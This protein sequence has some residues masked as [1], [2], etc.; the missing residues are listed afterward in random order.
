M[1]KS[2]AF[3][4]LS[5]EI[6]K[7]V[8]IVQRLGQ[9]LEHVL[10]RQSNCEEQLISH[11]SQLAKLDVA[12]LLAKRGSS[13]AG[14]T[15]FTTVPW[16]PGRQVMGARAD[17][18][19]EPSGLNLE[20]DD[21]DLLDIVR[22]AQVEPHEDE[23]SSDD[24]LWGLQKARVALRARAKLKGLANLAV[25]DDEEKVGEPPS[26]SGSSTNVVQGPLQELW[27]DLIA[28][29]SFGSGKA[30]PCEP[31]VTA[32]PPK[33]PTP[34]RGPPPSAVTVQGGSSVVAKAPFFAAMPNLW[35]ST[36]L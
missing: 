6:E 3:E 32:R 34:R 25:D 15:V 19:L 28:L 13:N 16:T 31:G 1:E 10:E 22:A 23:M 35:L 9:G 24:H 26:R 36:Q 21:A 11:T 14:E 29:R 5:G 12:L 20:K 4:L 27:T 18:L 17:K 2:E 7:L 33:V 30:E 8:S